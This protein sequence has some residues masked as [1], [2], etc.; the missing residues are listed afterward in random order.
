MAF[1]PGCVFCQI[2]A[3]Q[4]AA[5]FVAQTPTVAAFMDINPVTP[6]HLLVVAKDH[7]VGLDDTPPEVMVEIAQMGQRCAAAL[8]KSQ[9]RSEGINLF[10]ADGAAAFQEVFHVHLHVIPRYR[11]DGF[12]IGVD[13]GSRP[14]RG[15]LDSAAT[16]LQELLPPSSR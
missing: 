7:F 4:A 13:R 5:S 8:R 10:L 1:D 11:G 2:L 9:F 16:A 14:N 12:R 3:G 6:G 15:E